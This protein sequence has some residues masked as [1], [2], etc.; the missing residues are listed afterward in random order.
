MRK[1]TKM[2][3]GYEMSE[4]A[5]WSAYFE[6]A[7]TRATLKPFWRRWAINIVTWLLGD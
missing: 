5:M 2:I 6:V 1:T 3:G 7:K 4:L